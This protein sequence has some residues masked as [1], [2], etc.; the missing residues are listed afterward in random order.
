MSLATCLLTLFAALLRRLSRQSDMLIGMG[1]AGRER[2][3]LE[4]LIGFFVNI[5]P[6][7]IT[8]QTDEEFRDCLHRV[9]A[10]CTEA[11][12][13]QDYP[14]DLLV[15]ECAPA[16]GAERGR[17]LLNIMFEYQRYSD[18][19]GIN[20]LQEQQET[21]ASRS[22]PPEE[23]MPLTGMQGPA[24]KYA[25]TLFVQDEPQGCRLR[26]EY[27]S[28]LFTGA[29]VEQWLAT[30]EKLIDRVSARSAHEA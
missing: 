23:W 26:A 18:V 27:D 7:R 20:T 4:G 25:L 17:Q 30:L 14:F 22:I 12:A 10:A 1:V 13:R 11:L 16:S 9:E 24:A 3:E 21:Q 2:K 19:R 29:A 8:F 5:L 15:R 6:I 28:A